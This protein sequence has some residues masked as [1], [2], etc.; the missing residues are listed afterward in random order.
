MLMCVFFLFIR[1]CTPI[2]MYCHTLILHMWWIVH[3]FIS[4]YGH[5]TNFLFLWTL[6]SRRDKDVSVSHS[7]FLSFFPTC[8]EASSVAPFSHEDIWQQ[9]GGVDQWKVSLGFR[10]TD[11]HTYIQYIQ[12]IMAPLAGPVF[13]I[14]DTPGIWWHMLK[15][16]ATL[17][18]TTYSRDGSPGSGPARGCVLRQCYWA[19]KDR[20]MTGS[21]VLSSVPV[22]TVLG[23][24]HP[25]STS[26][27]LGL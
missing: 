8:S 25:F 1:V 19:G 14:G 16:L 6:R 9:G 18:Q 27:L 23:K 24:I 5:R 7:L 13:T 2:C 17:W 4:C 12:R 10:H 20:G 26:R 3:A 15:P 22:Q 21:S 11:R